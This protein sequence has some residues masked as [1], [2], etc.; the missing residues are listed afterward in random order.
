MRK[1]EERELILHPGKVLPTV[2][3]AE[4]HTA[5]RFRLDDSSKWAYT[6]F[7]SRETPP[8]YSHVGHVNPRS[9]K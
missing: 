2:L 1:K 3:T 8:G 9:R 5:V 6:E 4:H 7:A